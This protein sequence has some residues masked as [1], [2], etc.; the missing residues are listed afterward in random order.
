MKKRKTQL[1]LVILTLAFLICLVVIQVNWIIQ[2]ARMQ[3]AQFNHSVNMA[4]SRTVEKI[5]VDKQMCK[6]VSGCFIKDGA[7]R[8]CLRKIR[9]EEWSKV[10]S[11]IK[12]DLEFYNIDLDYEFDIVDIN[13][14]I[15]EG[16]I[17]EVL[18]KSY[19]TQSLEEALQKSGI[20]LNVKFPEKKEFVIA[21]I[22]VMFI[23]SILLILFV[24]V[25]FIIILNSYI[26]EKKLAEKTK[27][28]VNNMTHEFKTPIS[29]IAFANSM[30]RNKEG[31]PPDKLSRYTDIISI[32]NNKLKK[33]VEGLLQIAV[34][35]NKEND[36]KNE[37][38]DIHTVIN[39]AIKAVDDLVKER[40]GKINCNFKAEQTI[41]EGEKIHLLNAISNLLDNSNKYSPDIPE[42]NINTYNK[43]NQ[44]I[45]EVIDKGIGIS[46]EEQ[47]FIFDKFYR[48][49]TGDIHNVKGFGLGLSYVKM[50]VD[51]HG[52][53]IQLKS[54]KGKGSNFIIHLPLVKS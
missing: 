6:N 3:E 47:K 18:D 43:D 9:R 4:L 21:Q 46:N 28:F 2:A 50:V 27:D 10:D 37:K 16:K 54:T 1:I 8:S 32:E 31:L 23:S 20:Q 41:V 7:K 34:I 45:I 38:I 40:G 36:I 29:N 30:I 5:S 39:E 49:S 24:T 48:V 44:I 35:E 15:Q 13:E 26:K 53:K 17:N 51:A 33:Q 52:G 42:I 11:I 14:S 12:S 22:G 19:Y 25:S